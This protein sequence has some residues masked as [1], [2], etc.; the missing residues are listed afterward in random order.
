MSEYDSWDGASELAC[1]MDE[2]DEFREGPQRSVERSLAD[3]NTSGFSR[4]PTSGFSAIG[5]QTFPLAEVKLDKVMALDL[6]VGLRNVWGRRDQDGGDDLDIGS[7]YVLVTWGIGRTTFQAEV[8]IRNGWRYPF[9]A[10][11]LKAEYITAS[12]HTGVAIDE[13]I[14]G[15]NRDFIVAAGISPAS[16][17]A[18]PPLTRTVYGPDVLALASLDFPVPAWSKSWKPQVYVALAGARYTVFMFGNAGQ[19]LSRTVAAVSNYDPSWVPPAMWH[20]VPQMARVVQMQSDHAS[21]AL[22]QPRILFELG[23]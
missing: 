10:S 5:V 2:I 4:I 7:G 13:P 18:T 1:Y 23:I 22:T 6:V 8:D 20:E 9:M 19:L 3:S 16:G 21:Y 12:T 17:G 14:S 11:H 15:Q